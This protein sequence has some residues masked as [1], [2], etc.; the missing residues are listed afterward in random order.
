MVCRILDTAMFRKTHRQ[1]S[2]DE[3]QNLVTVTFQWKVS[4]N[5]LRN[6]ALFGRYYSVGDVLVH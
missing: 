4:L 1:K 2:R 5:W 6:C 3:D